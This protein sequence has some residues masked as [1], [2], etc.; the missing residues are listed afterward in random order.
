M[1]LQ[2]IRR[3]HS[4]GAGYMVQTRLLNCYGPSGARVFAWEFDGHTRRQKM[5]PK[6]LRLVTLQVS[7]LELAFRCIVCIII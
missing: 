3:Q 5:V 1:P 4:V 7:R 2:Y 6:V